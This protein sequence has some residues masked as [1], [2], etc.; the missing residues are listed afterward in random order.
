MCQLYLNKKRNLTLIQ[1]RLRYKLYIQI[2][3]LMSLLESFILFPYLRS[4]RGHILRFIVI[5][6]LVFIILKCCLHFRFHNI[7]KF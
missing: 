3:L 1:F 4:I 5:S 7:G 2:F 6:L